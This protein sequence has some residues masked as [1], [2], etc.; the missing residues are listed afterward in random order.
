MIIDIPGPQQPRTRAHS[1][2]SAFYKTALLFPLD[3]RPCPPAREGLS[4]LRPEKGKKKTETYWFW[5]SPENRVVGAFSCF[6]ANFFLFSGETQNQYLPWFCP[7]S[8]RRPENPFSSWRAG[9]QLSTKCC[10]FLW[11]VANSFCSHVFRPC[12]EVCLGGN[13]GPPNPPPLARTRPPPP[14]S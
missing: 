9:P 11:S 1:P 3:L 13:F 4:G 5:V 2:K 10:V 7:I 8:G 6:S 12:F 14:L